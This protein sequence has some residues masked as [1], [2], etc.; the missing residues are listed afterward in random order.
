LSDDSDAEEP[1]GPIENPV[2][3]P[4][5]SGGQTTEDEAG[6]QKQVQVQAQPGPSTKPFKVTKKRESSLS[7]LLDTVQNMEDMKK[8]V[9]DFIKLGVT[10]QQVRNLVNLITT[11]PHQKASF[12]A[13]IIVEET[14]QA[15]ERDQAALDDDQESREVRSTDENDGTVKD[16]SKEKENDDEE[17]EDEEEEDEE[18]EDEEEE[19]EEEEED[20]EEEDEEEEEDE[21]TSQAGTDELHSQV[22]V[23]KRSLLD[24]T[25]GGSNREKRFKSG[26]RPPKQTAQ[27][28]LAKMRER[29]NQ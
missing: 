13:P 23:P 3:Q 7:T 10:E 21:S 17:K 27:D 14:P 1:S 16:T 5:A 19:D 20:A 26:V 25:L 8:I 18:E 24:A 22:T 11:S 29:T 9:L 12:S 4:E 28:K 6:A 15:R 2:N